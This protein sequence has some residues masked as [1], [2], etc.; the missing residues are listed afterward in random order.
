MA[1]T[2]GIYVSFGTP[3]DRC[4]VIELTIEEYEGGLLATV[5]SRCNK[6]PA[7]HWMLSPVCQFH[8]EQLERKR[9]GAVT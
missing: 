7:A 1:I 8:H 6:E 4:S 3:S 2:R 9:G 5:I